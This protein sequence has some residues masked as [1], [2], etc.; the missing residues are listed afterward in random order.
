MLVIHCTQ[1]LL[2]R[3]PGPASVGQDTLVPTLGSWHANLVWLAHSPVVVCVNDNSLLPMLVPGKNFSNF[4]SAFRDRLTQ[5]LGRLGL[6]EATISMER[7][8]MER[9]QIQPATNRSVLGSLNDLVRLLKFRV[10]DHFSFAQADALEDML[11][12]T[13]M[14]ALKYAFPIE[15]AVAA[16]SK[17]V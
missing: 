9:I 17:F 12:K 11:S 6:P 2:K 1:K 5:R 15:V 4:C 16:F 10:E 14:G 7:A 3:N 8:A 13:P